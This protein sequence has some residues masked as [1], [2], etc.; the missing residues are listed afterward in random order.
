MNFL[1][2]DFLYD[3]GVYKTTYRETW[4][5]S[6]VWPRTNAIVRSQPHFTP[7]RRRPDHRQYCR[8]QIGSGLRMEKNFGLGLNVLIIKRPSPVV[9]LGLMGLDL[10]D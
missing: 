7:N 10:T 1:S 8:S 5:R 9:G 6:N 2:R 3:R 4:N